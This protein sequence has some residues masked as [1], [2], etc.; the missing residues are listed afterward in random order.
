MT[1]SVAQLKE[2]N[3][4]LS[5]THVGW[6]YGCLGVSR[7]DVMHTCPTVVI[8]CNAAQVLVKIGPPVEC[9]TIVRTIQS[10]KQLLPA[11]GTQF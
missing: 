9:I 1:V 7:P 5:A 10:N 8:S 11:T 6:E 2:C 3:T 4:L